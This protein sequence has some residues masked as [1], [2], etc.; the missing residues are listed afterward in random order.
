[1]YCTVVSNISESDDAVQLYGA[2]YRRFNYCLKIVQEKNCFQESRY[3][4]R[5]NRKKC[6]PIFH[7][8]LEEFTQEVNEKLPDP[9]NKFLCKQTFHLHIVYAV[10]TLHKCLCICFAMIICFCP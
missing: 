8:E 2:Q 4:G 10:L 5:A 1:M 6:F 7:K 9:G 3:A